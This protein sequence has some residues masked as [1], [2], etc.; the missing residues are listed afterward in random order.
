VTAPLRRLVDRYTST[1][2]MLLAC[3]VEVPDWIQA[4]LPTLPSVMAKGEQRASNVDRAV[5]DMTEAWLLRDRIGEHFEAIPLDTDEDRT[6]IA[7]LEPAIRAS[8]RGMG[9]VIGQPATVQLTEA[10]VTARLVRFT[11]I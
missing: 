9:F 3:G 5:V 11:K 6:K 8:A 1:L 7:I 2:C 10:D 4:A